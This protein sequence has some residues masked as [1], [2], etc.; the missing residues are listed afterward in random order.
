MSIC[1]AQSAYLLNVFN[2]QIMNSHFHLLLL[3][4]SLNRNDGD[5]PD[6]MALNPTQ[7]LSSTMEACC[8][9]FFDGYQFNAC[10]KR[11][12]LDHDD[13]VMIMRLF[14]PDWDGSNKGCNNDGK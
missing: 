12:P 7:W 5:E 9:K 8:K 2:V 10:M 4:L 14:Y 3:A 6:Y 1:S 11:Y 13:C